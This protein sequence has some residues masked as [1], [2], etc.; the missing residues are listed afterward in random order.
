MKRITDVIHSIVCTLFIS[1]IFWTIFIDSSLA[2]GSADFTRQ[3]IITGTT[4]TFSRNAQHQWPL[5][6]NATINRTATADS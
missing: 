2:Q 6:K 5:Q 1:V 4:P 3:G